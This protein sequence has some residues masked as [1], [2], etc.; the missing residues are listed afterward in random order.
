M[1]TQKFNHL[2]DMVSDG[3][4]T[5]EQFKNVIR[6]Y[7]KKYMSSRISRGRKNAV[8]KG[9][10]MLG[11]APYGYEINNGTLI[12]K[13]EE[14]NVVAT[15]YDL[16]NK[17]KS[18]NEVSEMLNNEGILTKRGR[19]WTSV[20]VRR[21]AKSELYVG[22]LYLNK[23]KIQYENGSRKKIKIPS[24]EWII[25]NVDPIISKELFDRVQERFKNYFRKGILKEQLK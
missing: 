15:I 6:E 12:V 3:I 20:T 18:A 24:D 7:E 23:T 17:G 21:I 25:I 19:E 2:F 22:N 5:I 16:L 10:V 13:A 8:E 11:I 9:K 14:A 4:I 1:N